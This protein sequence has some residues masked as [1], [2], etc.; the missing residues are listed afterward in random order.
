VTP[1]PDP[2]Q[3]LIGLGAAPKLTPLAVPSGAFGCPCAEGEGLIV[4]C[5]PAEACDPASDVG[6]L[7]L[8]DVCVGAEQADDMKISATAYK[9]RKRFVM[10]VIFSLIL[11]SSKLFLY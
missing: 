6:P 4:V 11:Q 1:R 8:T 3:T 5:A 2:S 10:L 7:S 9:A